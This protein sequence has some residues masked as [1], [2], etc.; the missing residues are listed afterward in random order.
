[1]PVGR[2][3]RETRCI[4]LAALALEPVERRKVDRYLDVTKSAFLFGGRV[5]LVEGIAEALL[6]PVMAKRIVLKDDADKLRLFRSAVFVPI[7]GVDFQPYAKLLLSLFNE[8]RIADRL[9]VLTDGDGG[10]VGE[11]AMTPGAGRKRD[12][13]AVVAGLGA[14]D[15]LEVVTND[16]SLETELV[17]AGNAALLKE[18]YVKL[19]PRS[20]DKWDAAVAQAGA[21]Q[22]VAIQKLF[23]TTRKGD[24]A[25]L[26]AEEINSGKAFTVPAYLK[27]AI[28]ALVK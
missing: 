15:L 18:V 11:G 14:G 13:E 25:Q 19:H 2:L 4:P 24:F 26:I 10:E 22:A 5:L 3:R 23:E 16:Y 8:V 7:D 17:R 27:A 6:L 28:E 9:V 1:M 20:A 12:L 21:A